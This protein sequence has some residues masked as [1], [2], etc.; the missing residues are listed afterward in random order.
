MANTNQNI[1]W[2]KEKEGK[3]KEKRRWC[4][5][6]GKFISDENNFHL[7]QKTRYNEINVTLLFSM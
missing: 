4:L 5:K 6:F 7:K 1:V 3:K 2:R